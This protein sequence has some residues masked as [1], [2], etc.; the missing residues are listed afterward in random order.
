M[1]P[2]ESCKSEIEDF[3]LFLLKNT[4]NQSHLTFVKANGLCGF[5][6]PFS[7]VLETSDNSKM[8][9]ILHS[10]IQIIPKVYGLNG[11]YMFISHI[12]LLI[13]SF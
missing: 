13:K 12:D 6:T 3:V 11:I 5:P 8:T 9:Y 2:S 4:A 7:I 10:N 1:P